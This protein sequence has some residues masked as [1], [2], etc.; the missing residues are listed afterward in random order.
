MRRAIVH[1]G[2]PRAGSTT[3]QH[4]LFR[5]RPE[6]AKAGILYPDLTPASAAHE[7]HINHQHFGEALDGRRPR[8][9]A[10]ELLER[11]SGELARTDADTVL[12]SYEDFIQQ[13]RA[14]GISR[15]LR[16][17]FDR[18]GFAMEAVVVAKPQSEHLN[19]VYSHRMQLMREKRLFDAFAGTFERS[20]RFAYRSLIEPW[21]SACS[22]RVRGVP[23]RDV[24]SPAPLVRRLLAEIG[25]EDRVAPLLAADDSGRVENRSPGP[26]AVEVSR[27]LRLMRVHARL[28]TPPRS[29]MR[30]VERAA[31]EH[32]LDQVPFKGVGPE[33]RARMAARFHDT[34]DRFAMALWGHAWPAVVAPEPEHEVNEIGRQ[35]IEPGM[36]SRIDTILRDACRQFGVT[37]SRPWTSMPMELLIDGSE[38]LQRA[39]RISRWRVT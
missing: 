30:A 18:H 4:I 31:M 35:P 28:H 12:I 25:L 8:R 32:G 26:V 7:P 20:G 9:E 13:K 1:I 36:E 2:M 17:L 24:R 29:M 37:P 38:A 21:L 27:R 10:R 23:V 33:L 14:A 5:L 39:F 15:T 3:F 34:N 11:L 22:G 19:S 16:S 6:L